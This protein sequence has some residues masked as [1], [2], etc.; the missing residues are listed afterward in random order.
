MN[1]P[2]PLLDKPE[3][4][5]QGPHASLEQILFE[6]FPDQ[7]WPHGLSVSGLANF[8]SLHRDQSIKLKALSDLVSALF[9]RPSTPVIN[10]A[11]MVDRLLAKKLAFAP[12]EQMILIPLDGS[13]RALHQYRLGSGSI[14]R[15][16][17]SMRELVAHL[18]TLNAHRF[19]LAHNH[20]SGDPTPSSK[21]RLVTL[22]IQERCQ[23]FD[24]ELVDHVVIARA[25]FS[26]A[27]HDGAV[28]PRAWLSLG[29]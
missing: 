17:V 1:S 4:L 6:L 18:L 3:D 2:P 25:G 13:G 16:P 29:S 26:S 14:D 28:T 21:D 12:T 23:P 8:C 22:Q 9:E 27:L 7:A 5:P 20:P 24:L 19:V 10:C 11:E 15:C